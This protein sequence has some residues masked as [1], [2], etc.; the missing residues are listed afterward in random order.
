MKIV[1][2]SNSGIYVDFTSLKVELIFRNIDLQYNVFGRGQY[3]HSMID[4]NRQLNVMG[5]SAILGIFYY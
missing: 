2:P 1:S 5:M 3:N 4:G